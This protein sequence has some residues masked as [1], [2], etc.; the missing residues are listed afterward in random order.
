MVEKLCKFYGTKIC[1]LNGIEYYSFP[2]VEALA[3][4]EVESKLRKEGF[5]YRAG[6]IAKS[7]KMILEVGGEKWFDELKSLEYKKAKIELMKLTGI[8]AKVSFVYLFYI[9]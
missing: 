7:A 3:Q 5:G 9:F 2:K 4:P 8:G 6:Y 1:E